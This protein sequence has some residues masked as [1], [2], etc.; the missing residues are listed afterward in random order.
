MKK[1]NISIIDKDG[2][3]PYLQV[4]FDGIELDKD[5]VH[6]LLNDTKGVDHVN[7][8]DRGVDKYRAIVY[9]ASYCDSLN[10][11]EDT[12]NKTLNRL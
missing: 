4:D 7:I 9:P 12:I 5:M 11:L 2:I 6:T 8:N 3:P 10:E 1:F